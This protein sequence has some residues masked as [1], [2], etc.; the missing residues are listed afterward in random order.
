MMRTSHPVAIGLLSAC[1][2]LAGCGALS[3]RMQKA[4]NATGPQPPEGASPDGGAPAPGSGATAAQGAASP[5]REDPDLTRAL[6]K[7]NISYALRKFPSFTVKDVSDL[8]KVKE[9]FAA[10]DPNMLF[11]TLPDSYNNGGGSTIKPDGAQQVDKGH[12]VGFVLSE[13]TVSLTDGYDDVPYPGGMPALVWDASVTNSLLGLMLVTADGRKIG[14]GYSLEG[15]VPKLIQPAIKP[16]DAAAAW[17][18]P[19]DYGLYTNIN[20]ILTLTSDGRLPKD[21][22]DAISKVTEQA[23]KCAENTWKPFEAQL[24]AIDLADILES[25]RENRRADVRE[26]GNNAVDR[27]CDG[28]A[29]GLVAPM[30]KAVDARRAEQAKLYAA[31]RAALKK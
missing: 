4:W 19:V 25:T 15:D 21:I 12:T 28:L 1:V 22:G 6:K 8:A 3:E 17:P 24:H 2:L 27:A 26:R 20:W 11:M 31:V 18:P 5:A 30:R 10:A 13:D 9:A 7:A 23:G 29:R 16:Y 14:A